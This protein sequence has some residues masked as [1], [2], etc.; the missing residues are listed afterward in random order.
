MNDR[1]RMLRGGARA[2]TG[3]L[4]VA[5]AASA[6]VLLGG[7]ALPE[8]SRAPQPIVVD[9]TQNTTRSLVC[10][11]SFSVLGADQA[12][13]GAA[14][15]TGVAAV[16]VS[17]AATGTTNLQRSEGGEGLPGVIAAPVETPLAAAQIQAVTGEQLRGATASACA[18]PLNE[19]WLVGGASNLGVST[20]LSLGNPGG[21]P[22]TAEITVY[23]ENGVVDA[24]QTAGVLVAPGTEQTIS[25][26]GY[27]PDRERFAVRVTSTGAPVTASLGVAHRY[28]LEA[29][30]VSSV[31]RQ[32]EAATH[33]VVPGVANASDHERGPNDSGEG[34][35]YPVLVRALAPDGA[36]TTVR[37]RA[38]DAKGGSTELGEI[39]LEP[40]AV[41]ELSVPVWPQGANAVVLDSDAPVVAG[42]LGS[43]TSGKEHD[44]EWFEPAP[45][46]AADTP[47]A[48]PIVSGGSLVLVNTGEEPATVQI[49]SASGA[50]KARTA[51]VPAGAAVVSAAPADAVLET[52]APIHAGVRYLQGGDIAGYPVLAPD[53]REG[54]L[55]IYTR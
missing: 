29:F 31:G 5:A 49:T 53:P 2:V 35:D 4:V 43:A 34:D 24:V 39:A 13:P 15:P 52:S 3:L 45:E 46:A 1:S 37:V 19:Q 32:V 6:V 33:L 51:T 42:V 21:V 25:L 48:A 11:G 50:S 47:I 8:V 40:N 12:R 55:T 38:I 20:T 9:T 26:N 41:G 28:G 23:D 44:Y 7:T 54:E 17:G 18:E 30:A 27:A 36:A 16:T 14:I 22:A 10:A